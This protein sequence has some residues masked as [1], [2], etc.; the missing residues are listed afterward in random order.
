MENYKGLPISPNHNDPPAMI[1][2]MDSHELTRKG[3]IS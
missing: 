1:T 3:L 2:G